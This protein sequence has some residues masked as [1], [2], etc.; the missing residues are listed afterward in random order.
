MNLLARRRALAEALVADAERLRERLWE[1]HTAFSFGG[2]DN[3]YSERE[4]AEPTPGEQLALVKAAAAAVDTALKLA[5]PTQ[6][7]QLSEVDRWLS[8]MSGQSVDAE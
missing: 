3:T 6:D 4:L 8:A 2:R 5:P 1:P 7:E